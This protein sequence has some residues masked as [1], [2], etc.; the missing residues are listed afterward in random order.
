[1]RISNE[2]KAG[3]VVLIAVAVAILFFIKTASMKKETYIIKTSFGYAGDLKPNATVKLSGIEVGRVK[4]IRFLYE[5]ATMIECALEIETD[6]KVRRDSVAY[7]ATSGFVGDAYVGITAGTMDEFVNPGEIIKSEDPMQ[8]RVFMK[9][10]DSIAD[11]LDKILINIKD[12]IAGKEDNLSK[13]VENMESTTKNFKEF[14]NDIKEHPW[15]LLIKEKE[16][17]KRKKK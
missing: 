8:S 10:A 17:R 13:I 16:K 2:I 5:P 3:I 15:K 9:K 12:F 14:S 6:A 4:E 11:S 7:I 1:M